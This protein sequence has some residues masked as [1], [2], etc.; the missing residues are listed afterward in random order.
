MKTILVV[1]ITIMGWC[2]GIACGTYL[3]VKGHPWFALMMF[4]VTATL[5]VKYKSD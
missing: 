4:F 3:V 5:S 1:L 2:F